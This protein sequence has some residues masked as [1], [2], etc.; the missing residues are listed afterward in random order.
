MD[1]GQKS[2]VLILARELATNLATPMFLI[3]A[4]GRLVFYNEAAEPIVGKPFADVGEMDAGEWAAM[5]KLT[6]PEGETLSG[7]RSRPAWRCSSDARRTDP[8][9][10]PVSTA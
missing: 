10:S 7:P 9:P 4:G 8:S 1:P 6:T 2:V 3:D 5:L